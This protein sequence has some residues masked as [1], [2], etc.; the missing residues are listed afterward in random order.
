MASSLQSVRKATG[1]CELER[2]GLRQNEHEKKFSEL[3]VQ[4]CEVM[5]MAA[6]QTRAPKYLANHFVAIAAVLPTSYCGA[7]GR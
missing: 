1:A 4:G 6:P 3:V 7:F 5:T 2:A